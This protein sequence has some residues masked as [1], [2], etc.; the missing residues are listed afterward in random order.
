MSKEV[1]LIDELT[2]LFSMKYMKLNYNTFLKKNK[3]AKII[4]IDIDNFKHINDQFGHEEGDNSLKYFSNTLLK[5]FSDNETNMIVR[6]SGDEFIILT[7]LSNEEIELRIES[8]HKLIEFYESSESICCAFRFSC[9]IVSAE[10][11]IESTMDKADAM[12]Y[13]AKR[14]KLKT[15]FY[16]EE[17]Y[18]EAKADSRYLTYFD[19]SVTTSST[20]FNRQEIFTIEGIS[21]GIE[22]LY[23]RDKNDNTFFE[24]DKYEMLRKNYRL[25][26]ID[27]LNLEKLF[28]NSRTINGK[29]MLNIHNQ[30][31]FNDRINFIDQLR[32]FIEIGNLN[33]NQI[34]L[35]INVRM[36]NCDI[37]SLNQA[38]IIL[39]QFGFE[40]CLD[41][42]S[43][44]IGNGSNYIWHKIDIDYMKICREYWIQG[45]NN[46]KI[47][48]DI[49]S[50]VSNMQETITIPIFSIVTSDLEHEFIEATG[51]K[52]YV[53][54]NYYKKEKGM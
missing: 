26:K 12:M 10:H 38:I 16:N 49:Q 9:G 47:N 21:T 20:H 51:N 1:N 6:R 31:L 3:S 33:P 48:K 37:N 22:E 30:T 4:A 53:K 27:L 44:E 34:I 54:G 14:K 45:I 40:I 41:S 32:N 17:T 43:D 23:T 35:S 7:S 29:I 36:L 5:V 11:G 2:K 13:E 42:Y 18:K 15:F 50:L 28:M 39:R 19:N 46:P 52:V 8:A 25:Q 24:Q